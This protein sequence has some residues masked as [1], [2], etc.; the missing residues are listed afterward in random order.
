MLGDTEPA[1]G[2]I[3]EKA[4]EIQSDAPNVLWNTLTVIWSRS[5][6]QFVSVDVALKQFMEDEMEATK[7]F[8][9]DPGPG[10]AHG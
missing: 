8:R 5:M 1:R 4:I 9:A 10:G 6:I 2:K 7:I 3:R